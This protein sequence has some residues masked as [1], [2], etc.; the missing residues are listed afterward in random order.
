MHTSRTAL[1]ALSAA[2]ALMLAGTALPAMAAH[3]VVN[4]EELNDSGVSGTGTVLYDEEAGTITVEINA[5]GLAEGAHVGHIHG[6]FDDSGNPIDSVVPPP[7]ADT[8]GDGFVEIG[9]GAV[10]YGPIILP[11]AGIGDV[12]ADGILNY[13]AT[14]DLSDSSIFGEGFDADDLF[15]LVFR[16]IVLHGA[17][18]PLGSGEGTEGIIN[19]NQPAYVLGLPVAAGEIS[20]PAPA[21]PEPGTWALMLLGFFGIGGMMR[22]RATV[23]NTAVNFAM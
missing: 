14:F 17:P 20:A 23:R 13:A 11:L 12:G 15:P 5:T 3:L 19:G 22:R 16:E 2:S 8:D 21:V 9:E 1:R 7:S 6:R 10:F 18:V 4:F